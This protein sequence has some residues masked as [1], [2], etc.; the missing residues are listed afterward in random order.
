MG[1]NEK[2][3]YTNV[4]AFGAT[5]IFFFTFYMFVNKMSLKQSTI[6]IWTVLYTVPENGTKNHLKTSP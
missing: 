1:T 5:I 3:I 2:K 4:H 6:I